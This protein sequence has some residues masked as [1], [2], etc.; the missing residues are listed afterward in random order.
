MFKLS[1]QS[2]ETEAVRTSTEHK[3]HELTYANRKLAAELEAA[4]A[5][6]KAAGDRDRRA[7]RTLREGLAEVSLLCL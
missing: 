7:L 2:Q 1:L 3:V 4:Q 5:A 6:A